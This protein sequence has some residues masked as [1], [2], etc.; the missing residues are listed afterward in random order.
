MQNS[1]AL[2]PIMAPRK[3]THTHA[4]TQVGSFI[5]LMLFLMVLHL[6][7]CIDVTSI[8]PC[9]WAFL[10]EAAAQDL[11]VGDLRPESISTW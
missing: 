1:R 4:R 6:P 10:A 11:N 5:A 2:S 7:L 3:Q 9:L 8:R